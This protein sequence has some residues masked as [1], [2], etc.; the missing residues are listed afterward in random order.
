MSLTMWETGALGKLLGWLSQA[1]CEREIRRRTGEEL[2]RILHADYYASFV[3]C[4]AAASFGDAVAINM[5]TGNLAAYER[6]FQFHDPITPLLQV[7]RRPTLVTQVMPQRDLMRTE[8]FNDF[9]A[10]DGLHHGVNLYAYAGNRNIG[11]LRIWRGRRRP[12]FDDDALRV[13]AIVQPLLTAALI[14]TTAPPSPSVTVL[15]K[16]EQDIASCICK[17]WCD[18]RI[19]REFGIGLST[20]RTH[21]RRIFQKMGVHSRTQLMQSLLACRAR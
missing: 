1:D 7:C 9:L 16:R 6:H 12:A 4:E 17:G 21:L 11:D 20:V 19:A 18:K 13:L 3:W 5:D 8:F 14:R 10:R 2:L 15:S